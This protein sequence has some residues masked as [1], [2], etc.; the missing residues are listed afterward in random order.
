MEKANRQTW[1]HDEPHDEPDFCD[2]GKLSLCKSEENLSDIQKR[3][4]AK[5]KLHGD[6]NVS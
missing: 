6:V 5:E 3:V 4:W 1:P 2:V